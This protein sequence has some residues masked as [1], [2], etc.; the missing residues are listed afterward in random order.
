MVD[1]IRMTLNNHFYVLLVLMY[2]YYTIFIFQQMNHLISSLFL[3][4]LFYYL[5]SIIS[6]TQTN[7]SEIT[8]K[9]LSN[10]LIPHNLYAQIMLNLFPLHY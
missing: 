3:K 4:V 7:Q 5:L 6:L 8:P 1:L 9:I 2:I 10:L